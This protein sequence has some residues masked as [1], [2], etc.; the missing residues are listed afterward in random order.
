VGLHDVDMWGEEWP[1]RSFTSVQANRLGMRCNLICDRLD[2]AKIMERLI[3]SL[4]C[5]SLA[6]TV[7]AGGNNGELNTDINLN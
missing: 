4:T 5:G 1:D 2:A 3:R 7:V 6:T